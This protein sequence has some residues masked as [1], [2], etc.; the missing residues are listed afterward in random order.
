MRQ[1][2][3]LVDYECSNQRYRQSLL[4]S[5][6]ANAVW[7]QL[8]QRFGEA[9]GTRIFK[10]QR[11]LSTISQNNLSVADYFTQIK[12][13]LDDYNSLI[14][15]A[16]CNC[17]IDCASLKAAHKL[18]Q[19]QQFMQFLVGL[20]EDYKIIRGSILMT[21]PLPTIDQVYALIQ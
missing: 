1:N 2:G 13:K 12:K 7:V 18:I 21:K 10:I 16:L 14:S 17:G 20:N 6:T 8:E 5:P 11:Y 19:D 4:F 15:I 9:D 3:D